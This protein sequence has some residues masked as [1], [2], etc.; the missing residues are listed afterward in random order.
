MSL[1]S[2]LRAQTADCHAAVDALFGNFNLS[3]TQDYK[4]F[5]RAHAR[6]VPSI[7][8]A[9]EEAGIARLLPDWPERGRAQLISAD[10]RELGDQLPDLLPPP[11]LRGEAA[12]WGAAYV[13][14]G[15]KLGGAMLARSV[16]DHLP[17]RYLTPQ[18]PKAAM[19]TFM[20]SLD[21]SDP[22]DPEAAVLAAR[23][24]FDLFL[25]AGQ[26]ELEAVA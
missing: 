6:V 11:A 18:G 23:S 19:R 8:H 26:L 17:S 10:I 12:I 7:E 15:S 13:L 20:E 22:K 14:E 4:A 2:A 16:P 25:E 5:L 9:L 21:A 3:R 24:I 1:R